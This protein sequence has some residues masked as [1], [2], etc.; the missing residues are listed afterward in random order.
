[1]DIFEY[2]CNNKCMFKCN[3][4]K[5]NHNIKTSLEQLL[6]RDYAILNYNEY[7]I[8]RIDTVKC[9]VCLQICKLN[10]IHNVKFVICALCC[11]KCTNIHVSIMMYNNFIGIW[12]NRDVL[13]TKLYRYAQHNFNYY[14]IAH[15]LINNSHILKHRYY[16]VVP[17]IFILSISDHNSSCYALNHDIVIFILKI[18]Y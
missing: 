6:L 16:H 1:M 8:Y 18:I 2:F 12:S 7:H 5:F 17:I 9:M 13:M 3:P 10:T 15:E 14:D 11:E 4:N